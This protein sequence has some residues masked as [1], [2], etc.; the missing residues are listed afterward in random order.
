MEIKTET[1]S[2]RPARFL[3]PRNWTKQQE[4]HWTPVTR[5]RR[6]LSD[7]LFQ[8][9]KIILLSSLSTSLHVKPTT[10]HR[11]SK[12]KCSQTSSCAL[13]FAT[14]WDVWRHVS[15]L[16]CLKR[17]K[18]SEP[19][20][21]RFPELL[22]C[23]ACSFVP[24]DTSHVCSCERK[25]FRS[26]AVCKFKHLLNNSTFHLENSQ[27]NFFIPRSRK[28]SIVDQQIGWRRDEFVLTSDWREVHSAA[29]CWASPVS[30]N[31]C[32]SE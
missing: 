22:R 26:D 7:F 18:W 13:F 5:V 1:K 23:S 14:L 15:L 6:C 24:A 30:E 9:L 32:S 29:A 19:C 11:A 20:W 21:A 4:L 16:T 10:D 31:T 12:E 8:G 25:A 3:R 28:S 27:W 17:R 2:I